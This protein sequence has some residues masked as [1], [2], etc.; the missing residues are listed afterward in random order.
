MAA[1]PTLL[2]SLLPT[3]P[4]C[5]FC[6][7]K[8]KQFNYSAHIRDIEL[9]FWGYTQLALTY[10]LNQF[11]LIL[12]APVIKTL[13]NKVRDRSKPT[14]IGYKIPQNGQKLLKI[15]QLSLIKLYCVYLVLKKSLYY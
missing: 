4:I 2:Y 14:K 1:L 12:L 8:Q 7:D 3:R 15:G 13:R 5:S 11:W 9:K 10:Y 6:T